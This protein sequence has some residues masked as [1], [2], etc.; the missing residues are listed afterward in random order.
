MPDLSR[1]AALGRLVAGI[2]EVGRGPLAGPVVAAAVIL[3]PGNIPDE[4]DGLDDS[5]VLSAEARFHYAAVIRRVGRIGIGAACVEEIDRLNI[6]QATMLAMTRAVA[7]LGFVPEAALIDGNRAPKLPCRAE[8]LVDGDALSL[9]IAAASVVAK[10]VRDGGM[11]RLAR[12]YDRYGWERNAGYGTQE[13]R[14]ALLQHGITPH[15]RRSFAPV[16]AI[17]VGQQLIVEAAID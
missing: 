13:H 5:K 16:K 3:D 1:E 14:T 8:T 7:A 10:V 4:L 12:R 17:L 11:A 2:D 9:S 6:L 15:H